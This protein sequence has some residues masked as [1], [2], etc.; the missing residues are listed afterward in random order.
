M[1]DLTLDDTSTYSIAKWKVKKE[2]NTLCECYYSQQKKNPLIVHGILREE[3]ILVDKALDKHID[4]R[5]PKSFSKYFNKLTPAQQ[6]TLTIAAGQQLA[7]GTKKL[8]A[9]RLTA[10]LAVKWLDHHVVIENTIKKYCPEEY[11]SLCMY[12]KSCIIIDNIHNNLI[13]QSPMSLYDPNNCFKQ[14]LRGGAPIITPKIKDLNLLNFN[15]KPSKWSITNE[16]KEQYAVVLVSHKTKHTV[17]LTQ[18]IDNTIDSTK[19]HIWSHDSSKIVKTINHNSSIMRA[20]LSPDG[21]WL[22][23]MS[24]ARHG[25]RYSKLMLTQLDTLS[26]QYLSDIVILPQWNFNTASWF[27]NASTL[28]AF[29]GPK[30]LKLFSLQTKKIVD[31]LELPEDVSFTYDLSKKGMYNPSPIELAFN[32]DDTRLVACLEN[33]LLKN[34]DT[35]MIWDISDLNNI[36]QLQLIHMPIKQSA[37]ATITFNYPQQDTVAIS[38]DYATFFFDTHSGVFLGKTTTDEEKEEKNIYAAACSIARSPITCIAANNGDTSSCV[39]LYNHTSG[40]CVGIIPFAEPSI[41]GIGMTKNGRSL[42]TTF[43]K[44]KSITTELITDAGNIPIVELSKK[45]NLVDFYALTELLKAKKQ[46]TPIHI[47]QPLYEYIRDFFV[48]NQ[49]YKDIITKYLC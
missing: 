12:L 38:T 45:M 37:D 24:F 47:S 42:V 5:Q 18:F 11:G 33:G 35:F 30:E 34:N 21:K 2:S 31:T 3:I 15:G 46:N 44:Y 17:T 9:L 40:K 25:K 39:K 19:L 20:S 8:H 41:V 36:K 43:D 26:D 22:V 32:H 23:T 7:D 10:Q 6:R 49:S 4:S 48:A 13:T 27:N 1:I 29:A 16:A 28:L 14:Y